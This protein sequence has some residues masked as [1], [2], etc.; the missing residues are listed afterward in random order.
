MR[1][2]INSLKGI[3]RLAGNDII[4]LFDKKPLKDLLSTNLHCVYYK[5][6]GNVDINLT[7]Y[8]IQCR[9]KAKITDED[10]FEFPPIKQNKYCIIVPN[11]NNN[12][13]EYKGKTYLQNCIDS[14]LG[15]TYKDFELVFVDDCSTDNSVDVVKYY[16]DCR[17]HIIENKRKR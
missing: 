8:D 10:L 12:H 9:K 14:I 17:I 5:E 3:E 4:Y 11:Y 13:G 7:D 15:Q 6:A 16:K 2:A 1:I